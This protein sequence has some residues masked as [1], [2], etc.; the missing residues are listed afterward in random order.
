[1][2]QVADMSYILAAAS[3]FN[4]DLSKW[5]VSRVTDMSHLF[6]SATNFN[7]DL[8]K[9][10]VFR[11][12]DMS[13]MFYYATSFKQELC[14]AAWVKAWSN[15]EVKKEAMFVQS[16]GSISKT[17]CT[18]TTTTTTI[19]TT[20]A[21]APQNKKE[22]KTAFNDC[23]QLSKV[24]DCSKGAHGPIGE[25]DVSRVTDMTEMFRIAISFNWDVSKWNVG[26]VTSMEGM[27]YDAAA[28]NQ[29]LSKWDVSQVTVM[30]SM[31]YQAKSFNQ[32]LSK[33]DVSRVINMR[34]MFWKVIQPLPVFDAITCQL[35]HKPTITEP[36]QS[37]T[38]SPP[39]HTRRR[40]PLTGTCQSGMCPK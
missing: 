7:Q 38:P 12:T 18:T 39:P 35:T 1:M 15:S 33:W 37:S 24:G 10:D 31:F 14:G 2:S 28:F 21:F 23:I 20:T 6:N 27:F 36:T 11:V 8:S 3:V 22:L 32:D 4:Q 30:L 5:D 25:W 9:W 19:T 13:Y 26:K 16:S 17:A 40:H 34:G 29:D